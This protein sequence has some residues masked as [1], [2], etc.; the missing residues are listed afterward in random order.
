[1]DIC[2]I[3]VRSGNGGPGKVSF[4]REK[5]IPKG[6]PDGGDGGD[7]GDVI[8]VV[9]ANLNTLR[10]FSYRK[11]FIAASGEPGGR[12]LKSGRAGENLCIK[13]PPGTEIKD[14]ESDEL[15]CDLQRDG[16]RFVICRGG[17]GGRG[18]DHFKSPTNQIPRRADAGLPGEEKDLILELKLVADVGLVGYPNAGKST[19]LRAISDA[20]P[21]IASYPFTT[22]T[23]NLGVVTGDD[24]YS[25]TVADIPGIIEGAHT[26]KG[27]GHQ[28]LRHIQRVRVLCYLLD[29]S[30]PDY[31]DHLTSLK[32]ELA[33]FDP[34]LLHR[35]E[36][37]LLN[38]IDLFSKEQQDEIRTASPADF[39]LIS[40]LKYTNIESAV[41]Q[42]RQLLATTEVET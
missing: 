29:I 12:R 42:L 20:R 33:E 28:F 39:I 26:G 27:L 38:K 4:R 13:V 8:F 16:E 36:V 7:G 40:A 34:S 21:K 10:D 37:V 19:F 17:K 2:E 31:Q 11:K 14:Q 22:L 6:G 5:F 15:I 3:K 25:F 18:N 24:Y 30:D 41:S 9:D 32:E 35:P 23:P 1:M